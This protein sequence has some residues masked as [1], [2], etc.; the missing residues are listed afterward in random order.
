MQYGLM[1]YVSA[2]A[3][4]LDV[5]IPLRSKTVQ[6]AKGIAEGFQARPVHVPHALVYSARLDRN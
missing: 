5:Y 2:M 1:M 4:S 6:G 3:S